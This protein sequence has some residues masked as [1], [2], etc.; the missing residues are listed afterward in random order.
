[1]MI[2]IYDYELLIMKI[3]SKV[4]DSF[5]VLVCGALQHVTATG[6]RVLLPGDEFGVVAP[7]ADT[8]LFDGQMLTLE[9]ATWIFCVAQFD[10][11]RVVTRQAPDL[12]RHEEDGRVVLVTEQREVEGRR[13][14]VV[15]RGTPARLLLG[16][17]EAGAWHVDANFADDLLLTW[18]VFLPDAAALA[19]RLLAWLDEAH[20]RERA[21]RATLA[22]LHAC[23]GDLADAGGQRFLARFEARLAAHASLATQL[24][25]LH[26]ALSTKA[27]PRHVTL[28]RSDRD[29]RLGCEVT[30]LPSKICHLILLSLFRSPA[31]TRRAGAC[32]W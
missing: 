21:I 32:S 10:F 31:A 9:D 13:G 1:M 2:M 14:H 16:L 15:V 25:L 12:V 7:T 23:H 6:A 3:P 26:A 20:V 27:R 8:V 30:L 29:E 4:L 18:R 19:D 17:V 28:T 24:R 22:W 5:C 11:T